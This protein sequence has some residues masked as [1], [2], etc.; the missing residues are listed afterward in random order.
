MNQDR[1][2]EKDNNRHET[3]SS[4]KAQSVESS[5]E[6]FSLSSCADNED[7]VPSNRKLMN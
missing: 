5:Q 4:S 6:D 2:N 7:F 3:Q 1:I